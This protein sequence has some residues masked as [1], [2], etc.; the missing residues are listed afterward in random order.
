MTHFSRTG[1]NPWTWALALALA[2]SLASVSVVAREEA[3]GSAA[4]LKAEHQRLAAELADNAYGRPL[5]IESTEARDR[6]E[7]EIHAVLEQPFDKVKAVLNDPEN[8]CD[9]LILHVNIKYCRAQRGPQGTVLAV[10]LGRKHDQPLEEAHR[11][12]F[13]YRAL[14]SSDDY[15]AVELH[16]DEG[17]FGTHDYQVRLEATPLGVRKT[18]LHFTYA[19]GFGFSGRAAMQGYLATRGR[20]KVGFTVTGRRPNGQ[21]IHIGGVRGVVERNT[22][23]Y[24]LAIE[25]YLAGMVAPPGER[26]EKRLQ[27]WYDATERYRRQLHEVERGE[28]LA[29]KRREYQ[30]QQRAE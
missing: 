15:F 10:N 20:S 13:D 26:L 22:M 11:V 2:I 6:L 7:G 14:G 4:A 30:R 12:A 5:H 28:Y 21:P 29:M 9:V 18:F 16:A 1:R 24:F 17:P 25:A 27:L 23:R 19:Y 8:W 3:S